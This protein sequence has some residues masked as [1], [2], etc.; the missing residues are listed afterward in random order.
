MNLYETALKIAIKAHAGQKRKHDGSAYVAHPIMVARLVEEAGFPESVVA[1]ALVHDVLEDTPLTEGMLRQA[2]GDEVVDI[3]ASVSEDTTLAWEERKAA[4]VKKVVASGEA[5]FAVSTADK[6]HNAADFIEFYEQK[7]P[8]AWTVFNRGK[9]E[10]I[11]FERLLYTELA[12]VW[13]H[14]LLN[15]YQEKI[16]RLEDLPD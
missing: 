1:A 7:G 8:L 5:A 10:K 13:Q 16:T 3:V 4:Y 9:A 2:L 15:R 12:R 6:I 11:W 14:P